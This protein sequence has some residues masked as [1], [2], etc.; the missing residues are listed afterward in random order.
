MDSVQLRRLVIAG[1]L[2]VTGAIALY[3][4][5]SPRPHSLLGSLTLLMA[6][7]LLGGGVWAAERYHP[8]LQNLVEEKSYRITLRSVLATAFLTG[9]LLLAALYAAAVVIGVV[10]AAWGYEPVSF[11][12]FADVVGRLALLLDIPLMPLIGGYIGAAVAMGA[13]F[14]I[15]YPY[16][17]VEDEAIGGPASFLAVWAY[18]LAAAVIFHPVSAVEPGSLAIDAAVAAVW[19]HVFAAAYEDVERYVP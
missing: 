15:L 11:Q 12:V 10:T 18:L 4:A 2:P 13:G 16:L 19:G 1:V 3:G 5:V 6:T 7:L 8:H 14:W 9:V 17:P